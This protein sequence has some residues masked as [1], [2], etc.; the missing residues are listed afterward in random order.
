MKKMLDYK[1]DD[2]AVNFTPEESF[3]YDVYNLGRLSG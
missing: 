2:D 1:A 3:Q